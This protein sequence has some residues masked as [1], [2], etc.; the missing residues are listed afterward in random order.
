MIIQ[1]IINYF[2]SSNI[3]FPFI[4]IYFKIYIH[5]KVYIYLN[6]LKRKKTRLIILIMTRARKRERS[7]WKCNDDRNTSTIYTMGVNQNTS[8]LTSH[9]TIQ[10]PAQN[11]DSPIRVQIYIQKP[12]IKRKLRK[13]IFKIFSFTFKN[14]INNPIFL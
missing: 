4:L 1:M 3:G 12:T 2:L 7:L 8:Q 10:E 5:Y 9:I 13:N 14:Y 6:I 11:I